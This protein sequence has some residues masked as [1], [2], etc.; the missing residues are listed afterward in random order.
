MEPIN[1]GRRNDNDTSND[2]FCKPVPL[3]A[4]KNALTLPGSLLMAALLLALLLPQSV[5]ASRPDRVVLLNGDQLSCGIRQLERG[6][7]RVA[8][9]SMDTVHI[10][11]DDIMRLSSPDEFIIE[12]HD[13]ERVRGSLLDSGM[14]RVLLVRDGKGD[15]MLDTHDV[16]RI[17]QFREGTVTD[18][19]DGQVS[20]GLEYAKA[21]D[22][23]A[24]SG[25]FN[26][27]R[28]AEDFQLGIDASVF[29]RSQDEGSDSQ[30]A[31]LEIEYRKLLER[32]WYWAALG[33]F[34]RNDE[35]GIDLRSLA[36]LGYGRF[37]VQTNRSLWSATAGAALVNEQR[38]GDEGAENEIE[39]YLNTRHEYFLYN[40]PKTSMNT[41]LTLF[42]SLTDSG[43]WRGN[44]AF[45]LRRELVKDLFLELRLYSY[46][47]S[48]PPD[49]GEK[50][51]YG[52][53]T[54]LGYSF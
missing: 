10:D 33:I 46:L 13:G 43:R 39:A 20:V 41:S 17:D 5:I 27:R 23:A 6:Q 8:T 49:E 4:M 36:G 38:A 51:D 31:S 3:E 54:S 29:L 47:D 7:L 11:W 18:H 26:A 30:R 15:R 42:P 52:F 1:E 9:D 48:R 32:R 50:S 28:K 34:E 19:W 45:F 14:D 16:V 21:N 12:L 35:L 24:L 22:R 40:L 2:F 37:L 44:L 53:V 25:N